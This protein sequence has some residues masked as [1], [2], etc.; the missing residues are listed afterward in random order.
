MLQISVLKCE[1][2]LIAEF[3]LFINVIHNYVKIRSL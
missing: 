3:K 1:A 2:V